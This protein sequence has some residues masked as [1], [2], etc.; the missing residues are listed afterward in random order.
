MYNVQLTHLRLDYC[1][2]VVLESSRI[3]TYAPILRSSRLVLKPYPGKLK[4]IHHV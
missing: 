4:A 2:A 1:V 3:D